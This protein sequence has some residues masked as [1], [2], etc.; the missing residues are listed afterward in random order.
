MEQSKIEQMLA[1]LNPAQREAATYNIGPLLVLAGP[2]SGKTRVLTSR[3]AWLLSQD[4]AE[5][6]EILAITFTNQ[7]ADEISQRLQEALGQELPR[8]STFHSW[9]YQLLKEGRL[10][11]ELLTPIDEELAKDLFKDCALNLGHKAKEAG[12]LYKTLS[13]LRQEWPLNVDSVPTLNKLYGEYRQQLHRLGVCDFD[14]LILDALRLLSDD[15]DLRQELIAKIKWILIDEFQDVSPAQYELLKLL[16]PKNA[17][18]TFVGDPCQSIYSFRG[19]EPELINHLQADF[20]GLE[21]IWLDICYRCP[22]NFLDGASHML[23]AGAPNLFVPKLVSSK[24][25]GKKIALKV[26]RDEYT[27]ARWIAR[28]IDKIVGGLSFDS[29]NFGKASGQTMRSFNEIAVLYRLNALGDLLEKELKLQG[30]PVNRPGKAV[31][32]INSDLKKLHHLWE[33][34]HNKNRKFHL[35]MLAA[36]TAEDKVNESS[37]RELE[38]MCLRIEPAELLLKL[39]QYLE[40]DI[41]SPSIQGLLKRVKH[42][43][44]SFNLSLFMRD[45]ADLLDL[46]F[47][48]VSLLTLH[49]AKGLEFPI[50]FVAGCETGLIPWKENKLIDEERRLFYVGLTRAEDELYLSYAKKRSFWGQRIKGEPS[51]FIKDIPGNL[52]RPI[53]TQRTKKQKAKTRQ[54]TLFD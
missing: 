36:K 14:E 2:G 22:Q 5:A 31:K 50:V 39:A 45:E 21:T 34:V 33:I 53:K 13:K 25:T 35:E 38:L 8:V 42:Q 29:I 41:D 43:Q 3:I 24:G 28:T 30:I 27:E 17:N 9:A 49:A 23:K 1:S 46:N 16:A 51:P 40:L 44:G 54:L 20:P 11:K 18:I 47:E 52:L 15:H 26:C 10:D 37:L 4:K 19:A 6:N 48:A 12:E 32:S 7:A